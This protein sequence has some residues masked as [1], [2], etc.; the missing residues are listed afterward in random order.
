MPYL[1]GTTESTRQLGWRGTLVSVIDVEYMLGNFTDVVP[2]VDLRSAMMERLKEGFRQCSWMMADSLARQNQYCVSIARAELVEIPSFRYSF[3]RGV[4]LVCIMDTRPFDEKYLG[5]DEL[6]FYRVRMA[7]GLFAELSDLLR[8]DAGS[9][10][11]GQAGY[12]EIIPAISFITNIDAAEGIGVPKS[13]R[14]ARKFKIINRQ[15]MEA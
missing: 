10:I 13:L 2:R 15:K 14:P 4:D 6:E 7:E 11:F 1:K 3:V 8:V 12:R 5:L 9:Y